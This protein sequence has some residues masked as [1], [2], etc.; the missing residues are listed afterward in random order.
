LKIVRRAAVR[1]AATLVP[2]LFPADC[3]LCGG[4]LPFR[5]EAG[6]CLSCWSGL[7]WRPGARRRR[8]PLRALAWAA[9]YEGSMR[10][11]VHGLKFE[12]RDEL[13]LPLGRGMA[14]RLGPLI[15]P[16][17]P[18]LVVPVPLHFWRRYRRG[19]N[20]AGLLADHLAR[21]L[22]L[23]LDPRALRR[24]RAGRRQLGLSRRERLRSLAGCFEARRATVRG[25]AVLLVDDVVT[26]GATLEECA[27]ALLAA[28]AG[29]VIACVLARTPRA[30]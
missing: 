20:Q 29:R 7:P 11:L 17:R 15:L 2:A 16:H 27:R 26:T 24:S 23:P 28:G 13:A 9:D 18:D 12:D 6:V 4:A 14:A 22:R 10:R 19:Y 1:L 3:V 25:R 8:G 30:R 21:P 5:H